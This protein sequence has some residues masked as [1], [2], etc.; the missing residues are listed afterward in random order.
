MLRVQIVA[1][2]E[3][4]MIQTIRRESAPLSVLYPFVD[5]H[6]LSK[7]NWYASVGGFGTEFFKQFSERKRELRVTGHFCRAVN[8]LKDSC[9]VDSQWNN[10]DSFFQVLLASHVGLQKPNQWEV[11][12]QSFA[13]FS[14]LEKQVI[15]VNDWKGMPCYHFFEK[16]L[17]DVARLHPLFPRTLALY[18]SNHRQQPFEGTP[19]QKKLRV[20]KRKRNR[21]VVRIQGIDD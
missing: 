19:P 18:V 12:R 6:W 4:K 3:R 17:V 13:V 10:L 7:M 15:L 2:L 9:I 20:S 21:K 5:A 11:R 14:W 8:L 1:Q 16:S